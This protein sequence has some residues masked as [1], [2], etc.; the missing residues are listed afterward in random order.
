MYHDVTAPGREDDS[1]FPGG[2]AARYKL[3]PQQFDAHVDAIRAARP[4][5][6]AIGIERADLEREPAPV[7]VT[8]D[9]G[10]ASAMLIAERLDQVGWT[11]HFFVTGAYIGRRGFL[12]ASELRDLVARGH[13]VGS[14]SYSHPLRM[15]ALPPARLREEWTRSIAELSDMLSE[16]IRTASVPGGDYSLRVAQTAAD[17]GVQ[18]LF[19]SL[20]TARAERVGNMIVVGRYVVKRT[21]TA[22]RVA[23]VASGSAAPRLQQLAWWQLKRAAKAVGGSAYLAVRG[24]ILRRSGAVRWGDE[25]A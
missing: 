19:T 1:G 14:H 8:F 13:V 12:T 17:A 10:G 23:A 6:A 3:E 5:V 7:I 11:G 9:D 22:A 15:A 18:Y 21:T 20:P 16:P 4:D 2:D 25:T 24:R